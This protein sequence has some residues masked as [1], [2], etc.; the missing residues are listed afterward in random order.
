MKAFNRLFVFL[1][2]VLAGATL[3]LAQPTVYA[4]RSWQED[5]PNSFVTGPVKFKVTDPTNLILIQHQSK[6]GHIRAGAYLNYKWYAQVTKPGTQSQLEGL[7]T[8]D[9]ET[10]ERT[11]ISKKGVQMAEMSY[12]Y[13]TNTMY[14]VKVNNEYLMTLD[15]ETGEAKQLAKFHDAEG[16]IKVILAMAI[17]KKGQMYGVS[18][19]DK[20][21]K[22]DKATSVCDS[23]G[24]V[25]VDAAFTQDMEFDHNS[26][27]LYWCNNGTHGIYTI[28]V[29]TGKATFVGMAG[30]RGDTLGA[31]AIPYINVATGAPDR[32]TDRKIGLFMETVNTVELSWILPEVDAQGK[33]LTE[34]KGFKIYR[35]NELIANEDFGVSSAQMPGMMQ[36]YYDKDLKDG[37]Y[38]YKIVAYN[39]A[40][41]GGVE[42][43]PM[44]MFIGANAPAGVTELKVVTGDGDATLT[45][46]AP[47]AGLYGGE[48]DPASITKYKVTRISAAGE[49]VMYTEGAVTTYTDAAKFGNFKYIVQAVNAVGEGSVVE[50]AEVLVKPA[51][52]IVMGQE[53]AVV[54]I[55]KE[56]LFYDHAGPNG[57]YQNSINDTIVIAPA[58]AKGAVK[59][60]FTKF[61]TD[62]YDKMTV[63]HGQGKDA[64]QMGQYSGISMPDPLKSFESLAK[65]GSLTIA[66]KSDVAFNDDG[67]EAKVTA[68]EKKDYDLEM[69]LLEG[70]G[71]PTAEDNVTYTVTLMN[72]GLKEMKAADYKVALKTAANKV[73]AEVQ[74]ADV[75]S[76]AVATVKVDVKFAVAGT[77][78]LTAE[79]VSDKD[80]NAE[81]NVSKV[82]EV[83]VIEKGSKYVAI[84][85]PEDQVQQLMV[86]PVSFM[87]CDAISETIYKA[88]DINAEGMELKMIQFPFGS[89]TKNYPEVP[90]KVYVA[91]TDLETLTDKTF[92]PT[93]MTLVF[94]GNRPVA[95]TDKYFTF[96]LDKPYKYTGK[97]LVIMLHKKSDKTKDSG[98]NF[99]GTY[100]ADSKRTRFASV[101]GEG[102]L[103]LTF[104]QGMGVDMTMVPNIEMLFSKAESGV[105]NAV[106][107]NSVKV[108]P[109]PA[110]EVLFMSETMVK[111]ELVSVAGQVVYTGENVAEINVEALPAGVYMLTAENAEGKVVKTKVVKK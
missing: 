19:D 45:W 72:K 47:T 101:W 83:V 78:T 30:K 26:G 46:K 77:E 91:E 36:K 48:F 70:N 33:K 63:F 35:N 12:D 62:T 61:R 87:S 67:W 96:L 75:E 109:N 89:V 85:V 104:P 9:M 49:K 60:E 69:Q 51:N 20:F 57:R 42:D 17:D 14:A 56:Y 29:T 64:V 110:T 74:G 107:D 93:E 15:L 58:S 27:I 82:V 50:S 53:K 71:F 1:M 95:T 34:I 90:M 8:L 23:I 18:M 108:Y 2:S 97:N 40:G 5:L 10:G 94:D 16:N 103:D 6:L 106:A 102:E 25:G 13:T 79:I 28:D 99:K 59:V 43:E 84:G 41:D 21:Y 39:T 37:L 73:V 88:S 38:E 55:G 52:W 98:V 105:E 7:Y 32:V 76:L 22:I 24:E 66:F 4:Y 11:L 31:L 54:E 100:S 65:G 68:Y 80:Q 111:V 92:L 44:K 81:N 86:V 3:L